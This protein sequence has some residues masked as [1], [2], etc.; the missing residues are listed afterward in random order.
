M[1]VSDTQL[2]ADIEAQ[3]ELLDFIS[4]AETLKKWGGADNE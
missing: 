3:I 4:A 2:I 1:A